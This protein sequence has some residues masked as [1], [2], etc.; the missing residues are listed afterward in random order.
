MH[1]DRTV[2]PW[3]GSQEQHAAIQARQE[4]AARQARWQ[5]AG[6]AVAD[7]AAAEA[8]F[9]RDAVRRLAEL[10]VADPLMDLN[11]LAERL[12]REEQSARWD[13]PSVATCIKLLWPPDKARGWDREA[14][15]PWPGYLGPMREA[16]EFRPVGGDDDRAGRACSQYSC[17]RCRAEWPD[18]WPGAG[19]ASN[20]ELGCPD[21]GAPTLS[22]GRAGRAHSVIDLHWL[23]FRHAPV[24]PG[25]CPV[26]A[27][28]RAL[29]ACGNRDRV[30]RILTWHCTS[31]QADLVRQRG[32]DAVR[33]H[34]AASAPVQWLSEA[35]EAAYWLATDLLR[36]AAK[37]G[38][39]TELPAG[40][41]HATLDGSGERWVYGGPSDGWQRVDAAQNPGTQRYVGRE[42]DVVT[43]DDGRS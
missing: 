25:P 16:P 28:P 21:C 42:V 37:A 33:H 32:A 31:P 24:D 20:P 34:A 36:M 3:E 35:D 4:Q 23:R 39:I 40:A 27:A 43:A 18:G 5:R 38:E 6:L 17:P 13:W 12:N 22:I 11:R 9:D 15:G 10:N 8:M 29:F 30:E 7:F 1:G 2:P 41:T 26:C 19:T 14:N